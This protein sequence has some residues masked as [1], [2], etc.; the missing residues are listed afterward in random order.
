M[1]GTKGASQIAKAL[2]INSSLL[3]LDLSCTNNDCVFKF[4]STGTQIDHIGASHIGEALK[5][6]SS[7]TELNLSG[8][9]GYSFTQLIS[10]KSPKLV[11]KELLTLAIV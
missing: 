8:I 7:L 4:I 9:L 11:M 1:I 5:I 2:K 10:S 6:N 3:I